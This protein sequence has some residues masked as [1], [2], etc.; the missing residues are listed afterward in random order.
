MMTV[1]ASAAGMLMLLRGAAAG[2]PTP[3][4]YAFFSRA[5][6]ASH[7]EGHA[8]RWPRVVALPDGRA[9]LVWVR[10]RPG[11]DDAI[12]AA[13]S[14][15]SGCAWGPPQLVLADA[16]RVVSAPGVEASGS[17]VLVTCTTARAG[18]R[19]ATT[20]RV[21]STDSG[22]S[23]SAPAE[24][25]ANPAAAHD[26]GPAAS[27]GFEV[28]GRRGILA[29]WDKGAERLPLCAAASFDDAR[30]WTA[31]KD[32]A[33][34]GSARRPSCPSC[35]QALDG[36]LLTVW[37]EDGPDG[38]DIGMARF[39][40]AWLLHEEPAGVD[41][42]EPATPTAPA[43][44]T[45]S[46]TLVLFGSS[47]TAPRGPLRIFGQLL[48]EELP[49]LGV[50]A[51]VVNAGVGGN[52]TAMARERFERDVLT[53]NPD[54]VTVYLGINDSAVDVWRGEMEPRVTIEQYEANLRY[55][56]TTLR[57]RGAKAILLTPNPLAWAVHT[58]QAYGKPPYDAADPDGFNLW[59]KEY[60]PVVRR[61][62]A[63]E[64]VPLVDVYSLFRQ[65]GETRPMTDLLLDGMHPNDL[66]HR[67][68]ADAL[69]AIIPGLVLND[70]M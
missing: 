21:R 11:E 46:C 63:D 20:W 6:V 35:T 2:L 13:C 23:W 3:S 39:S 69:L 43:T 12:V 19:D 53:Q 57:E 37:Q 41:K 25:P 61:I 54:V 4:D 17:D 1:V 40:L 32:V 52:T 8:N 51:R 33:P 59:L 31:A 60:A 22:A 14:F 44:A 65:Y 62:A 66:G 36:A 28:D 29:L 70:S 9:L 30:T 48:E 45:A 50:Q 56:V 27:A 64:G 24:G 38:S 58:K 47:T 26:D 10:G 7:A 55:F 15:D 68:I 67:L 5:V 34:A 49:G 42:A 16:G 18:D